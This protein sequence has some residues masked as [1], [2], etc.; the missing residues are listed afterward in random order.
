M[1]RISFTVVVIFCAGYL[2][3]Q[4]LKKPDLPK[5]K[6]E[7][8]TDDK[9]KV[10]HGPYLQHLDET[11]VSLVWVTNKDAIAWVELA[12]DDSSNFYKLERPRYFSSSN[13]LKNVARIHVVHIEN[14]QPGKKYRYRIFSKEVLSHEGIEVRYGEVIATRVFQRKAPAFTTNDYEKPAISFLMLNDIH[15]R[16]EVMKTL[17][18]GTDWGA[19]D[20]V[21]FDGDM[22]NSSRSEEQMFGSFMDTADSLFAGEI[23]MYYSRGNH[24]TRGPF[25]SDFYKYF[26]GVNGK[27]YYIFRQ[28]PV[29]FIILDS[30]EDKPDSDIEYGGIT[31]FDTYRE[32]EAQWLK[33]ALN[34]KIFRDAPFKIAVAHIPPFEGWHGEEQIKE[35]FAPLLNKAGID[36]MLCAHLHRYVRS[37]KTN[38]RNFPV[39]VNSNNSILKVKVNKNQLKLDVVDLQGSLMDSLTINK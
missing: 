4:P 30:G 35:K 27:L 37:D 26:P 34:S 23:P 16:N 2:L 5:G 7:R 1:K 36:I 3:A 32:E 21:L 24:E 6:Q 39:I 25:A 12:P 14:L 9:F 28:G 13:G 20:F 29:C 19:T 8:S 11:S 18:K 15:E 17:L 38:E 31:D 22:V 33:E 10:L